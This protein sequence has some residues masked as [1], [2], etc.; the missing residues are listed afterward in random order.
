MVNK[1][2]FANMLSANPRKCY[3]KNVIIVLLTFPWSLTSILQH[4]SII[5]LPNNKIFYGGEIVSLTLQPP[6]WR[7][8]VSLFLCI[9]WPHKPHHYN[10]VGI[11]LGR[12]K[13]L[14]ITVYQMD[15]G[16]A[17]LYLFMIFCNQLLVATFQNQKVSSWQNFWSRLIPLVSYLPKDFSILHSF[18]DLVHHLLQFLHGCLLFKRT[19]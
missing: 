16:L 7:T 8:R 5:R 6:T 19:M 4:A 3:G 11:P 18:I 15:R 17:A 1:I 14:S 10:K 2:W 13:Y 12:A 9:I